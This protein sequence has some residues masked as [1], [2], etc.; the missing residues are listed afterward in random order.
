MW[1]VFKWFT[2]AEGNRAITDLYHWQI[3]WYPRINF[4]MLILGMYFREYNV[5]NGVN[6]GY[7]TGY[8]LWKYKI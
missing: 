5:M 7:Y 8:L 2:C 3:I 1:T 6:N 4:H